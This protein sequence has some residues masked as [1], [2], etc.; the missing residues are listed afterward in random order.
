MTRYIYGE[1]AI[2]MIKG[3]PELVIKC[4]ASEEVLKIMS[5]IKDKDIE[6]KITSDNTVTVELP[7]VEGIDLIVF[8]KKQTCGFE[9]N[10][11]GCPSIEHA[12][13]YYNDYNKKWHDEMQCVHEYGIK[14][15]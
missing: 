9:M 10:W 2:E 1:L 13:N 4:T 11:Q 14:L 12:L 5:D 3:N 15:I 7:T 8:C 6:L